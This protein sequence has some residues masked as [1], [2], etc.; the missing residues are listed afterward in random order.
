MTAAPRQV[1]AILDAGG[2]ADDVLSALVDALAALPGIDWA[3]I[4]FLEEGALSPGPSAGTPGKATRRIVPILYRGD[5]VGELVADGDPEPSLL[6]EVASR[7][8]E[9]VLL[10]WDTGGLAWE[11]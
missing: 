8:G 2:E 1:A 10:G 6:E 11:P 3:G 7:I 9:Y 4:S 5:P